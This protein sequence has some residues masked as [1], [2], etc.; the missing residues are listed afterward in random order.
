MAASCSH[1]TAARTS[2][3]HNLTSSDVSTSRQHGPKTN[4]A[5]QLY[6]TINFWAFY[7]RKAAK[8]MTLPR[9]F[10][11]NN[12]GYNIFPCCSNKFLQW[13][14]TC[15]CAH[16][17]I[18]SCRCSRCTFI[19]PNQKL[20]YYSRLLILL[21]LYIYIYCNISYPLEDAA[22]DLASFHWHGDYVLCTMFE[23]PPLSSR[24]S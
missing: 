5:Y 4:L 9:Y 3:Y 13:R 7:D 2:T 19:T 20:S 21:L 10:T 8:K 6:S 18:Y 12:R 24:H 11:W 23:V 15:T 17:L 16:Y 1:Y 14:L 22:G